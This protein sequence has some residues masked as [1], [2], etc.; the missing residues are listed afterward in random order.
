MSD[1]QIDQRSGRRPRGDCAGA[2]DHRRRSRARADTCNTAGK[3][4]FEVEIDTTA[5]GTAH[6]AM[7]RRDQARVLLELLS[8]AGQVEAGS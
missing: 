1:I 4:R 6:D 3:L 7:L 2:T 5:P 8:L